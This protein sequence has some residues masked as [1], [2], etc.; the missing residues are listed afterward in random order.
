MKLQRVGINESGAMNKITLSV[1]KHIG[2]IIWH[3]GSAAPEGTLLCDGS[4]VSRATYAELFAAI[5]TTFGTGDGSTTFNVPDLRNI[6]IVGSGTRDVGE[7]VAEGLPEI[8]GSQ[9]F[10]GG[11]NGNILQG[12]GQMT[13]AL[14]GGT[15]LNAYRSLGALAQMTGATS[16]EGL[17]FQASRSNSIYGA[18]AHVTP[19]SVALTPCIIY[20]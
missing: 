1:H 20:E 10:H 18:S 4:A 8:Q 12:T 9:S 11:Q 5:G 6:W 16:T 15:V 2:S 17:T 3:G 14:N 7:D 13:G 19:A